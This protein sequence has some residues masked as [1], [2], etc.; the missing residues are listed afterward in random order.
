MGSPSCVTQEEKLLARLR[1]LDASSLYE[2]VVYITP[3]K[4]I[5]FWVVEKK[6]VKLE[7][8]QKS[9]KIQIEGFSQ[10]VTK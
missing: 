6:P 2:I 7:G 9:E 5:G 8:E 1:S 10:F 3:E 4:T